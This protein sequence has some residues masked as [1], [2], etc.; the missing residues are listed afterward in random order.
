MEEWRYRHPQ[1][2]LQ[3]RAHRD[4]DRWLAC[5]LDVDTGENLRSEWVVTKAEAMVL[6]HSC[7]DLGLR[8]RWTPTREM[9][10]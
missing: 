1:G 7:L 4:G 9:A 8:S 5:V 10:F 2:W 6:L 3:V